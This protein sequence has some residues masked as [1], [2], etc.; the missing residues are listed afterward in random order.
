MPGRVFRRRLLLLLAA[1]ALFEPLCVRAHAA[2]NPRDVDAVRFGERLQLG[3]NWLF[4][5][6]DN[7]AWASPS[8]D[9]HAW[10]VIST[11]RELVSY[12]IRNVRYGWYRM[13]IH[14]RA[15]APA[16]VVVVGDTYGSYEVFANGVHIGGNGPMDRHAFRSQYGVRGFPIPSTADAD[17]NL[18]LAIR[19][20]LNSVGADGPGTST[21]L[22]GNSV[23]LASPDGFRRDANDST[24]RGTFQELVT[25]AL[26]L[27]IGMVAFALGIPL[28]DHREYLAASLYLLAVALLSAARVWEFATISNVSQGLLGSF[29]AG[30]T[31]VTLIEFIRLVVLQPR[32]RWIVALETVIFLFGFWDVVGFSQPSLFVFRLGFILYFLPQFAVNL[33]LLVLLARALRAGNREAR[34]LLPAVLF[35]GLPTYWDFGDWSLYYLRITP[36]LHE[37]PSW[38]LGLYQFSVADLC[39]IIFLA[40]IL[41][42]LVLRTLRIARHTAE[43][44]A[45]LEAA[46]ATQQLLLARAAEPTPGFD[47]QTVYHPASEV[48]GDF[49]AVQPAGNGALLV[50]IGDV[51][52]KGIHAAMTVSEILGALRGCPERRPAAILRYLNKVLRKQAGGFVTC[53]VARITPAGEISVA[54]AGHLAPYCNGDELPVESGLPLGVDEDAVWPETAHSFS[55]GERLTFISDGVVEA[56]SATG[57]LYGFDRMRASST[58]PAEEIAA[59]ARAFGQEDD[60]TALTVSLARVVAT[61]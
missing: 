43:V 21:A 42:F 58:L 29:L 16:P 52:G 56:R 25:A 38:S 1:M 6:G 30:L 27:L 10:A 49:F 11:Q 20:A 59:R 32:R 36:T 8:F 35:L 48:G 33:V 31:Y 4:H 46:R 14:L 22:T 61:R 37:R 17:G 60:I 12:G 41:L 57:E 13:H 44:G 3:P 53:C 28:R 18:V 26:A 5:P 55:E 54:N 51:S 19:F 7:P 34:F 50:T 47:V 9:D 39:T 23:V 24:T 40:A 45:E 2:N 15:G